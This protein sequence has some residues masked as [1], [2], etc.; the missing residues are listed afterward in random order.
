MSE[1]LSGHKRAKPGDYV[2]GRL[3]DDELRRFVDAFVSQQIFTSQHVPESNIDMLKVIFMPLAFGALDGYT[4]EDIAD[5]GIVYEYLDAQGPRSVNGY[6][7]FMSCRL[8]R[9][10]DWARARGAIQLE[11]E[12]R[13]HIELPPALR[14][15]GSE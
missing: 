15:Q 4:P 5:I 12:R 3:A 14:P 2:L 8:M 9:K 1:T 10:S 6:P 11:T 13:K 7:T